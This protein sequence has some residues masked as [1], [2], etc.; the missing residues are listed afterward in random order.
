MIK[1][2]ETARDLDPRLR[3]IAKEAAENKNNAKAQAAKKKAEEKDKLLAVQKKRKADELA[4]IAVKD[5]TDKAARELAR[6]E[7]KI[8]AGEFKALIGLCASKMPG[9]KVYD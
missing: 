5:A 8:L 1:L 9:S 2:V 6:A 4:A 7:A 3:R